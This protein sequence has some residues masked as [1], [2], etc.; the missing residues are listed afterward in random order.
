LL[1]LALVELEAFKFQVEHVKEK[2]QLVDHTC[3][4]R[5]LMESMQASLFKKMEKTKAL[6]ANEL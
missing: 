2:Q 4:V 5:M 3:T 6:E 1:Q